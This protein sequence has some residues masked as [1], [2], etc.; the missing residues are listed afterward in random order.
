MRADPFSDLSPQEKQRLEKAP[1][2]VWVEPMLATSR[3]KPFSD[4]GWVFERKFDGIRCLAFRDGSEVRLFTRNQ[5]RL[6]PRFP[7]LAAQMAFQ[8][9]DDFVVDGE[10]AAFEGERTS[11][12]LLQGGS[13]TGR[14]E[15]VHES[16]VSIFYYVFDLMHLS[17]F[18]TRALDLRSRKSLL[19]KELA[20]EGA[21]RYS[22]HREEFGQRYFVEACGRGWEGLVAKRADSSYV[23][24]RSTSW[25]KLK[26]L[27]EQELVVAGFTDPSGSRVGF[28]ALLLGYYVDGALSYAGKVG[29]GFDD[30]T[31]RQLRGMLDRLEV[32]QSP[33]TVERRF[34]RGTHFV[35]PSLVAQIGFTEWTRD[36]MLRHPK[37]V[38]LRDDKDPREVTRESS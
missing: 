32:D 9:Q 29:T 13:R 1:H 30:R 27:M 11:F 21:I 10:I 28:G 15:R 14:R 37:F 8:A 7:D 18:D 20:F 2:P 34:E 5:Q 3:E 17:G 35:S 33:F 12:A 24:G 16:G 22:E 26:C 36:G 19:A 6:A 38:G 4:P 25:L 23:S 31:L